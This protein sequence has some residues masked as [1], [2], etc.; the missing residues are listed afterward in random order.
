MLPDELP[1]Q[2][3]IPAPHI[4]SQVAPSNLGGAQRS[5]E[6]VRLACQ[7]AC[8]VPLSRPQCSEDASC[9]GAA[10]LCKRCSSKRLEINQE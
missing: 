2:P 10:R 9:A 5:E 6:H 1:S 7:E 4:P 3:D 8:F